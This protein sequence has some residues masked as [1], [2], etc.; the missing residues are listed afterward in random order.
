MMKKIALALLSCTLFTAPARATENYPWVLD[1]AHCTFP[2]YPRE[3]ARNEETGTTTL[4]FLI[5]TDG[6]IAA[7]L[8]KHSSGSPVLDMA[9]Q[10]ALARC[11]FKLHAAVTPREEVW[12]KMAYVWQLSDAEGPLQ[13]RIDFSTCARAPYP[14][15]ARKRD[16]TGTV[17]LGL[18][19]KS[20][21]AVRET[22]LVGSS[23]HPELDS[24]TRTAM[25]ACRF[26]DGPAKAVDDE[27]VTMDYAWTVEDLP[28]QVVRKKN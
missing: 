27:W 2:T 12:Q 19:V 15:G 21:G 13:R 22:R 3:A 26:L 23:G 25:S 6:S 16:M 20:D 18:L 24:A 14:A 28:R 4:E 8:V 5:R 11:N 10:D 9:A 7:T 17:S 1:T